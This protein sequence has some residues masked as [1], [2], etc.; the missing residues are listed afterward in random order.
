MNFRIIAIGCLVGDYFERQME[1]VALN[2]QKMAAM[3]MMEIAH[4]LRSITP[5][6]SGMMA[7]L[8]RGCDFKRRG[9]WGFSFFVGWRAS[10]F[11]GKFYAPFTLY[12]TGVYGLYGRPITP[13]SAPRLAWQDKSG[14]WISK[15]EVKGQRPRPILKQAQNF[16]VKLL[17]QNLKFAYLR[18][19]RTGK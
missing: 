11:Y 19:M 2:Q 13:R 6:R 1:I 10:D 7:S 17:R 3:S 16:G 5:R 18:S 8:V 4:Y 14:K 9:R 12:G 15:A